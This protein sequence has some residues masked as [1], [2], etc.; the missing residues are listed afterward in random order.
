[1]LLN[2][3]ERVCAN[4]GGITHWRSTPLYVI[5]SVDNIV[6][7]SVWCYSQFP[8]HLVRLLLLQV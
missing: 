6:Q 3:L 7:Q 8:R 4:G 5:P 1:M 2:Y